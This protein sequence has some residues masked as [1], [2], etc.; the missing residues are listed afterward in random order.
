[1]RRF[2]QPIK[3]GLGSRAAFR[4][5]VS[6]VAVGMRMQIRLDT[7]RVEDSR[8]TAVHVAL[9][10]NFTPPPPVIYLFWGRLRKCLGFRA[11]LRQFPSVWGVGL[12][13]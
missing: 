8:K 5:A 4:A 7:S 11:E 1:M 10:I 2:Q 3:R 6:T 9:Q 13:L 12:R